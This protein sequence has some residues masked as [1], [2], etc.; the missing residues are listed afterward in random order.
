MI[1][2]FDKS[3]ENARVVTSKD[4]GGNYTDV[5]S[6]EINHNR[7]GNVI[8][9]TEILL[10]EIDLINMLD[11]LSDAEDAREEIESYGCT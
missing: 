11:S 9:V 8:Y 4:G 5:I 3:I 7:S 6:L 10:T 2:L 1:T